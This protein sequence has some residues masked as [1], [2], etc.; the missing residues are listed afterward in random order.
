MIVVVGPSCAGKTTFGSVASTM[1]LGVTEGSALVRKVY[2]TRARPD[3]DVISFCRRWYT[4]HGLDVFARAH[5]DLFERQGIDFDRH[6]FL[7][8][9][10]KAEVDILRSLGG[11]SVVYGI[12]ADTS[13]RYARSVQRARSDR[14]PDLRAFVTR[15]MREYELG[16]AGVFVK[17]V[18]K[19]MFNNTSTA[20]F[21]REVR[22]ELTEFLTVP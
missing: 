15:D 14:E 12:T 7:G 3:E 19:F 4:S 8:C 5:M 16:L 20:R 22:R 11:V 2:S 18:D 6:V 9:K 10:V 1:G 13:I 17:S 21:R